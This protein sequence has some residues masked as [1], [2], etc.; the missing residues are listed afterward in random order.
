MDV[1]NCG[2]RASSSFSSGSSSDAALPSNIFIKSASLLS[3]FKTS[4]I[5]RWMRAS[6]SNAFRKSSDC[7]RFV[8]A[9]FA[10]VLAA[11]A[12]VEDFHAAI[13][14]AIAASSEKTEI[15]KFM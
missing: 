7:A 15:A 8:S 2:E 12:D 9:S 4:V 5:K 1:L 13:A 11:L 10:K 6:S 3:S 14:D